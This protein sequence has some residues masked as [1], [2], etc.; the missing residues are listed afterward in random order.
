MKWFGPCLHWL[1]AVQ[2][3]Q[4]WSRA[5][6]IPSNLPMIDS[7]WYP[8]IFSSISMFDQSLNYIKTLHFA[9]YTHFMT[10]NI[11]QLCSK[12][13]HSG[14]QKHLSQHNM[15]QTIWYGQYES[16]DIMFNGSVSLYNFWVLNHWWP[17]NFYMIWHFL[18]NP[19][20]IGVTNSVNDRSFLVNRN[21]PK[22]CGCCIFGEVH[23]GGH[24]IRDARNPLWQEYKEHRWHLL[25]KLKMNWFVKQ[26]LFVCT[27]VQGKN[28][29]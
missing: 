5:A 19:E 11:N 13:V 22:T 16:Y 6:D 10:Q 29:F 24:H 2:F 28:L 3:G 1:T 18:L 17:W 23:H 26:I 7:F 25:F 20:Q 9:L 8:S 27:F 12:S 15:I 21:A 14:I 4:G